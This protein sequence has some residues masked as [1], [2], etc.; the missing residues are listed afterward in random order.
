M[1]GKGGDGGGGF[2]LMRR[3]CARRRHNLSLRKTVSH[4]LNDMSGR[5]NMK[6]V[7]VEDKFRA[8]ERG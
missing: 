3:A 4:F 1:V 2:Q 5:K 6:G 8:A 7:A